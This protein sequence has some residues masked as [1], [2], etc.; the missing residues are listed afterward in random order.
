MLPMTLV[1]G[2]FSSTMMTM[3]ARP[4]WLV[5]GVDGPACAGGV[6]AEGDSDESGALVEHPV[7]RSTSAATSAT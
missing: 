3:C 5:P 7:R 4:V 6:A 2:L 1:S